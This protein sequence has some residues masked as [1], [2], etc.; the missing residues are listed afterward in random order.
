LLLLIGW[1]P[2]GPQLPLCAEVT[3]AAPVA[4]RTGVVGL[5]SA[6]AGL[7]VALALGEGTGDPVCPCQCTGTVP[8]GQA[9]GV[10]ALTLTRVC[11]VVRQA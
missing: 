9:G 4:E 3:H 8:T 1:Y 7:L 6:A 10:V 5:E 11:L 2:Y